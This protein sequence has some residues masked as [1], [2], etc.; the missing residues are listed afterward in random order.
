[1]N[2][3]S[4]FFTK[5]DAPAR[6]GKVEDCPSLSFSSLCYGCMSVASILL[7]IFVNLGGF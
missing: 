1:M 5:K 7:I 4:L 6:L 3:S 2:H